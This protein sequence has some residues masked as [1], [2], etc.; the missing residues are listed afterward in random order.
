MSEPWRELSEPLL[1]DRDDP[2]ENEEGTDTNLSCHGVNY[3]VDMNTSIGSKACQLGQPE[4]RQI[5]FDVSCIFKNGMTAILGKQR[6]ISTYIFILENN[7]SRLGLTGS[8]KSTLLD[9]LAGRQSQ[10]AYQGTL[11]I[12]GR[13]LP[14]PSAFGDMVGYVTQ[15]DMLSED[16]TVLENIRFAANLRLPQSM[17]L[18]ERMGCVQ[19]VIDQ[20]ELTGCADTLLGTLLQRGVSGGQRKRTCIAMELVRSPRILVLDEPTTGV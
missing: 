20:M 18:E 5:L 16:L 10:Q 4:R 19:K 12:N 2:V 15:D 6:V 8:G 17:P 7:P 11:N 14:S 1:D 13:P 3:S 9:I